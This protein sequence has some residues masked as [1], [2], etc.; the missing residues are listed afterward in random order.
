MSTMCDYDV[1]V[2]CCRDE[3]RETLPEEFAML[4]VFLFNAGYEL[5]GFL[6]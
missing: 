4:M 2:S 6:D 5:S 1:F 3:V